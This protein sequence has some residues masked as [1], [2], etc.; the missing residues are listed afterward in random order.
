MSGSEALRNFQ[1]EYADDI[2]N[3]DFWAKEMAGIDVLPSQIIEWVA[4]MDPTR[5]AERAENIYK[6]GDSDTSPYTVLWQYASFDNLLDEWDTDDG[7]E[8]FKYIGIG[9]ASGVKHYFE[10]LCKNANEHGKSITDFIESI[11]NTQEIFLSI[12]QDKIIGFPDPNSFF[13]GLIFG[14]LVGAG[15]EFFINAANTLDTLEKQS[16]TVAVAGFEEVE[17]RPTINRDGY[18]S[19]LPPELN[20]NYDESD[21]DH[22]AT[23][24]QYL[25]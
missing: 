22:G 11:R 13:E 21:H 16:G 1:K 9:R 5:L 23:N 7:I 4:A 3:I 19:H 25:R 14:L 2:A 17:F 10:Q 24:D 6:L 15:P 18:D 8:F 20:D 12:C